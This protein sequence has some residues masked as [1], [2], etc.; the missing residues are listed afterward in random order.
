MRQSLA[1]RK[2]RLGMKKKAAYPEGIAAFGERIGCRPIASRG[3]RQSA[4]P[5]MKEIIWILPRILL[6][7]QAQIFLQQAQRLQQLPVL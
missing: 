7:R 1:G 3:A 2:V 4:R 5:E 6:L